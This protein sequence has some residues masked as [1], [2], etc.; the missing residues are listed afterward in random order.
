MCTFGLLEESLRSSAKSRHDAGLMP[1]SPYSG[2]SA[3]LLRRVGR[4]EQVCFACVDASYELISLKKTT[5]E[6]LIRVFLLLFILEGNLVVFMLVNS[7]E[8]VAT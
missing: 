3:S 7:S 6:V 4:P 5:C 1:Q 8:N 2:A